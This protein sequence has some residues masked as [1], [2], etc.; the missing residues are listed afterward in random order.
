[1]GLDRRGLLNEPEETNLLILDGRQSLMWTAIPAIVQSVNLSQMTI[2]AQP[3]IQGVTYDQNNNATYVNLPILADV[4]IV[5]PSAGGF[6][7]TFPIAI[8]DEVLVVFA[9]RCIDAWW[10]QGGIGLPIEMRMHDLSDGFAIPG[11]KSLPNVFG[12]ISSTDL[13]IRNKTGSSY[14]SITSTG[15]V[16]I[17]A[18][19]ITVTGNLNVTGA[20]VATGE[21][22]GGPG[23]I[24]LTTH[25]HPGVTSGGADTGTPIP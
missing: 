14:I 22:T 5:F 23:M 10:Q 25:I 19:T 7:I 15:N 1:M 24:P 21:I 13:Q 17:I 18:P 20:I 8:N 11:P 9:S 3:A 6:M 4:P 12:G 2:T 16:K